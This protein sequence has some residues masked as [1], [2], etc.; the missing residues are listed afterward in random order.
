MNVTPSGV[1]RWV[2]SQWLNDS[3]HIWEPHDGVMIFK[4]IPHYWPF[5]CDIRSQKA[6]NAHFWC[7]HARLNKLLKKKNNQIVGGL[8]H[9]AANVKLL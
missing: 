5:V 6:N 8:R 7:F 1:A 2:G 9:H 4:D 3:L